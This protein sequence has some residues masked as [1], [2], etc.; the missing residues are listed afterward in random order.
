MNRANESACDSTRQL[1]SLLRL[2]D[3]ETPE[4]RAVVTRSLGEFGGDVSE[5]LAALD[6]P[7]PGR[8]LALL[9]RILGVARRADLEQ[10][11]L[12][13]SGGASAMG[14]DWEGF[15]A[16]LRMISDFLHDGVTIRQPL[17]DA[18][19]LLA[20]DAVD[21][22]VRSS[23]DLRRFLFVDGRLKAN[24]ADG[25][26][27][28]N[29][30]LA[31][32]VAN[33]RSNPLGLSLVFILVGRRLGHDVEGVDYPGHFLCRIYRDG[34]PVVIDC[35]DQGRQHLQMTLL[36]SPDLS[37]RERAVIRQA[38]HPGIMMTRLVEELV[39][40]LEERGREEDAVLVRR[41]RRTLG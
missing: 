40:D 37:R 15:E 16:M 14:D 21:A 39:A 10:D 27:P 6:R 23:E 26:D 34:V 7:L 20:D 8:D 17:S 18:L 28:R 29:L 4:V 32:V 33:G 11:W 5:L 3:D 12:A 31:W 22:G 2:L 1:D 41:L 24:E 13:P 30:D 25:G 35:H 36:E 19:D 9:S 38:A